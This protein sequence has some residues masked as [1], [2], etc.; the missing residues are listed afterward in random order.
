M[1]SQSKYE[2]ILPTSNYVVEEP[3]T[4]WT[5]LCAAGACGLLVVAALATS[6]TQAAAPQ[7]LNAATLTTSQVG[8]AYRTAPLNPMAPL[9]SAPLQYEGPTPSFVDPAF[10]P[11][12]QRFV[13]AP[14]SMWQRGTAYL[15]AV[16]ALSAAGAVALWRRASQEEESYDIEEV[17]L[18]TYFEATGKTGKIKTRKSVAKRYKVTGSGK[19]MRKKSGKGHMLE[20]KDPKR[21]MNLGQK[22][23]VDPADEPRQKAMIPYGGA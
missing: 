17:M 5:G 11:E 14:Q 12:M 6:T 10:L 4:Q 3:K 13:T 16:A 19:L 8:S 23:R 9:R 2:A 15:S 18:P 21:K 1:F 20:K 22:M 7:M